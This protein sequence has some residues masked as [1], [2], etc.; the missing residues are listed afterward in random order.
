VPAHDVEPG[1]GASV[2]DATAPAAVGR[3]A[4]G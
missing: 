1:D 4:G 3:A 2:P